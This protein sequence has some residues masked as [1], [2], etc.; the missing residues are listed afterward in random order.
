MHAAALIVV[1][2]IGILLGY[3]IGYREGVKTMMQFADLVKRIYNWTKYKDTRWAIDARSA[4]KR[5]DYKEY[6]L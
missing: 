5:F 4:L 2:T 1:F 3:W 6:D